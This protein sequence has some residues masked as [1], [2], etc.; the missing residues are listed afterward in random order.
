MLLPNII[1]INEVI[2]CNNCC[3][4]FFLNEIKNLKLTFKEGA[5]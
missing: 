4:S 5:N 2:R 1:N 3:L